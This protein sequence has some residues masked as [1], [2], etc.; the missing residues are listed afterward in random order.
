MG[1]ESVGDQ[2]YLREMLQ[3]F[4]D[5]M[6]ATQVELSEGMGISRPVVVNFL[7]D[8]KK[9]LPVDRQNLIDLCKK[10]PNRRRSKRKSKT[11][12][13]QNSEPIE[14]NPDELRKLLGEIG[15]DELLESAGFLPKDT[16]SIKVSKE[17]FFQVAQVV[18]WLEFLDFEDFL[19]TT[20]EFL[21]IASNK[22]GIASKQLLGEGAESQEN[23]FLRSLIDKLGKLR[24][25]G[26][27]YPNLGLKLRLEIIDKLKR[28]WKRLKAG[29]KANFTRQEA[30]GLFLS[31]LIKEQMPKYPTNLHLIVEKLEFKILSLSVS[32]EAAYNLLYDKF[33]EIA[34]QAEHALNAQGTSQEAQLEVQSLDSLSP[35]I[36]AVITCSFSHDDNKSEFLEWM[37][38]SSNTMVE[39]AIGACSLHMGFTKDVA[40]INLFTKTL[41]TSINSLVETTVILGNQQGYQGIW[42]DRD[43]MITMLQAIACAGKS[44]LADKNFSGELDLETYASAFKTLSQLRKQLTKVRRDF[45][46]YQFID[47]DYNST[48]E[49]Y[50][51]EIKKIGNTAWNELNKISQDKIYFTYRLNFYRCYL[52]AKRLNLRL[53]NAQGDIPQAKIIIQEI[54]QVFEENK[55]AEELVPIQALIK[56]EV[57]L[58]ELSCGHNPDLFSSSKR[59]K[60]LGLEEWDRKIRGAIRPDSCYKDPGLDIYQALSEIYGNIARIEFYLGDD[61]STLEKS[62]EYFLKAA[63]YASRIGLTQRMSRWL[64]LAGRVWVRLGDENLSKQASKFAT[65]LAI[66]DLPIGHSDNFRQAVISE[67][68]L[69]DGERLLL[70]ENKPIE[71]LNHF[72]KALKGAVYL[73]LN[74]RIC[75]ALFNISRC[76]NKLGNFSTKEGISRIFKEEDQLTEFNKKK[77][78]RMKNST[79]EKVLDLLFSL[80]NREDNPT[81]FQVRDE[82]SQLAAQIWQGW[83][84]DSK[85]YHRDKSELKAT[86]IHPIAERIQNESWLCQ[87]N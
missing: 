49:D 14:S 4:L 38:T 23:D 34:E 33:V 44:W 26:E 63:H 18:A 80:W 21:A 16:S 55:E 52:I 73:G 62:T 45:Q 57:Y 66:T 15:S 60:W 68:N 71:A 24:E 25:S 59:S 50:K 22:V 6:E 86:T 79:S 42:V 85:E 28:I 77:L 76:S 87:L 51:V 27:S 84:D 9:Q 78:N 32:K 29:G 30:I 48:N 46:K 5:K 69:L 54:Q 8:H 40:K 43:S 83:H 74:R 2:K 36:M 58:Y 13:E 1:K 70:I 12:G 75:D 35:V 31:I 20:Q 61:K 64:A 17:K 47:E 67:I 19:P 56:S 11:E 82:F 7:N 65:K 53:S 10:L 72:L 3:F 39:N 37:Y 81:W 41:D